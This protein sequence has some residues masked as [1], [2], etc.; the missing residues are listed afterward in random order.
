MTH[1]R[2]LAFLDFATLVAVSLVLLTIAGWLEYANSVSGVGF[3]DPERAVA[4]ALA[5]DTGLADDNLSSEH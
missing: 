1:Q 5:T 2:P 3:M 4:V